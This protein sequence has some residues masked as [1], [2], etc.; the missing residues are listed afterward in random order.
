MATLEDLAF[1]QSWS[2]YINLAESGD[3]LIIV[4]ELP[5]VASQDISLEVK[6]NVLVLRGYKSDSERSE[7]RRYYCMERCHGSFYREIALP[8]VVDFDSAKAVLH[9]GL[10][11]ITLERMED[12]RGKLYRIPIQKKT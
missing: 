5:G 8:W 9:D 6:F 2:P 3:S 7:A 11:R 10:L 4:A 1:G 12:R